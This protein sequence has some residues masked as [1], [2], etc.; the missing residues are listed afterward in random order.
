MNYDECYPIYFDRE[1]ILLKLR[2]YKHIRAIGDDTGIT[3]QQS[4]HQMVKH[5]K[6]K[7]EMNGVFEHIC[8]NCIAT[9]TICYVDYNCYYAGVLGLDNDLA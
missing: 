8:S 5:N 1:N 9:N 7:M 2:Y 4:L 3:I 6:K